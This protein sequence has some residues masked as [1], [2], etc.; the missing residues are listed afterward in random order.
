MAQR[1]KSLKESEIR[2]I[3]A[4]FDEARKLPYSQLNTK[5]GS[6]TIAEMVELS[7]K[8]NRWYKGESDADDEMWNYDRG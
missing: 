4:V 3:L 2:T 7:V 8:L 5:L 6:L 1:R